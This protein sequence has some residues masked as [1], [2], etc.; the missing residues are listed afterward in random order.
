M[1]QFE[2]AEDIQESFLHDLKVIV[3]IAVDTDDIQRRYC[4][5]SFD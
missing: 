4:N 1:N 3:T 2:R 5:F